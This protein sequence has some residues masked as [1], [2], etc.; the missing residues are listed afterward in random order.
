[1]GARE[2]IEH[3]IVLMLE[4]RSF[5]CML[6]TLYPSGPDFA[7][8]T[9]TETNVYLGQSLPVWNNSDMGPTTA[10]IPD[11]DPG[12]LFTDMNV[13]LFGA[14]NAP[15]NAPPSMSGFVENYM[16]QTTDG[17]NHDPTAVLHYFT[18][19]QVPVISTL[20]KAFGVCDQ[21]YASAPCQTWPNRF[22]VHTGTAQG[23]I[24]NSH[25]PIPFP[26]PSIFRRMEDCGKSWHVYF[27]DVPQSLL[28][29]DIWLETALHF[30]FFDQF[31][32]DAR[33]GTLPNY[34]FIEPR[35]F[36]DLP[37][38]LMPND[39][40]PP[41]NVAFGEQLIATAYNAV[42]SSPCW[43]KTL[44]LITYD[45]HGGCYDHMPPPLAPKPDAF[46]QDGFDFSRYGVR[47]PA[48][49]VSPYMP[50][51]STVRVQPDGLPH[52]GPPFPFDHTSILSTLRQL[53]DLGE[54]FTGRDAVAPDLLGSLSLDD[55]TNDGPPSVSSAAIQPTAAELQKQASAPPNHMQ[56]AL[57]RAS[58]QLS[59]TPPTSLAD[60]PA[61]GPQGETPF[62]EVGTAAKTAISRIKDFLGTS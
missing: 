58:A 46:T 19:E 50:P 60:V 14:G 56:A 32:V 6:G 4:N 38:C 48:V 8:L 39:G 45:E 57:S 29:R 52:Q 21:W 11:P 13:Q 54:P 23:W 40:H 37:N 30:R 1:M 9:G 41:H 44:L 36:T 22:F 25:F 18:P 7:G 24:D 17:Q 42:R 3:V 34:T 62:A 51:G 15:N 10:C 49:I 59:A 43:K 31:L 61:P 33:N 20:A 55:P 28:L 16:M 5:D 26:A 2:G 35:Y 47:V 53:F 12:E 27:H